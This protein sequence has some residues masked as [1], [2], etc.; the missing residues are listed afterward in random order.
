MRIAIAGGPRTGKSTLAKAL[1][2]IQGVQ[3]YPTD[4]IIKTDWSETSQLASTWFD[5]APT[6]II[7]GVAVPRAIRK[8]LARNPTG[9]PCDKLYWLAPAYV[10]LTKGQEAMSKGCFTVFK[11]IRAELER[12]GVEVVMP[13]DTPL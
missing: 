7:E 3:V 13:P 4:S 5:T 1:S 12:R 6:F 11:E 2:N 10:P 8:W 9:K